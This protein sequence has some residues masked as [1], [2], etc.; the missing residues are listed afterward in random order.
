ATRTGA[1]EAIALELRSTLRRRGARRRAEEA[2]RLGPHLRQRSRPHVTIGTLGGF[3]VAVDGDPVPGATWQ[4]KKARDIIKILVARR[5]KP[6]H[7]EALVELLWPDEDQK[8]T[9]NRL[10]VALS[11]IRS[12]LDPDR[13]HQAD[14]YLE[15]DRDTV[16]LRLDRLQVDLEVFHNAAST[17]LAAARRNDHERARGLLE[18]AEATYVGDLLEEEP[19]ED[20]ATAAREEARATYI[21]VARWLADQA[22]ADR[23]LDAAVRFLLRILQRD[24]FDENAHLQLVQVMIE[25]RRPGEARRLY[26]QYCS[27]ME[28]LGVEAAPYP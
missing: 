4:S 19:Y 12:V 18:E 14:H 6:L 15:A 28:E 17:G 13:L 7:R 22:H 16:G 2:D 5:G 24:P 8:K 25:A 20:W 21:T 9:A 11:V 23:D 27:R 26:R 10:S 3:S 1:D